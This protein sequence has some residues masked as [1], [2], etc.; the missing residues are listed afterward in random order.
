M[1][2]NVFALAAILNL[3]YIKEKLHDSGLALWPHQCEHCSRLVNILSF[4]QNALGRQDSRYENIESSEESTD[5]HDIPVNRASLYVTYIFGMIVIGFVIFNILSVLICSIMDE[6][7]HVLQSQDTKDIVIIIL[8]DLYLIIAIYF[9]IFR[10]IPAF[11]DA[12]LVGIPKLRWLAVLLTGQSVWLAFKRL[13]KP[14]ALLTNGHDPYVYKF[15]ANCTL[16]SIMDGAY[17]ISLPFFVEHSIMIACFMI[18]LWSRFLPRYMRSLTKRSFE[19][20]R[21][22]H[23]KGSVG[24]KS[25]VLRCF[26]FHER[27]KKDNQEKQHCL[28]GIDEP[29]YESICLQDMAAVED[30]GSSC[31][32]IHT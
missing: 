9:T 30:R 22:D 20:H 31:N 28:R 16:I 15:S 10:F 14:F 1:I 8:Y 19:A 29:R 11:F 17:A 25:T 27:F 13:A 21:K 2:A 23:R 18:G 24:S 32:S 3:L 6:S 12:H 5:E 26:S 4:R 7:F